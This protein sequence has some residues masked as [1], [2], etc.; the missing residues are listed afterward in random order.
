MKSN[1]T[2]FDDN[3]K[4]AIRCADEVINS[5]N[6]TL[7]IATSSNNPPL[8]PEKKVNAVLNDL[9]LAAL[10]PTKAALDQPTIEATGKEVQNIISAGF[11]EFKRKTGRNMTYSEMRYAYG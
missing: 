4:K 8:I 6:K 9:E 11:D 3:V 1:E 10:A 5:V 7:A 2:A